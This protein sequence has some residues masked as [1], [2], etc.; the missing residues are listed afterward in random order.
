[1]RKL[2]A[3]DM[4]GTCLNDRQ[5]ISERTLTALKKAA[6]GG[7]TIVPTTGRS[8]SFLPHQLKE[9]TFFRYVITSNGA[10]VFDTQ[11]KRTVFSSL[12]PQK[13]AI[14]L[15]L[16][17]KKQGLGLTVHIDNRTVAEGSLLCLLG[18][19]IYKKDTKSTLKTDDIFQALKQI[20]SDVEEIQLFFFN[21]RKKEAAQRL[22]EK[23]SG[24]TSSFGKTYVEMY[25][26]NASKGLAIFKLAKALD[27]DKEDIICI[28]NGENDLTMFNYAG[29]KIAVEN[30]DLILKEQ[31]DLIV[32]SNNRDG[33]ACAI[34]KIL[35]L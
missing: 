31:A 7:I 24:F 17:G 23:S 9:Q 3:V 10:V 1:M 8:L 5:I 2:L 11:E 12:I 13:A 35:T 26:P 21:K 32:P 25:S 14:N 4:D 28:G 33:V 6:D 15:L 20:N 22:V 18:K 30:A 19:L 27:I 16:E 34:E 29:L